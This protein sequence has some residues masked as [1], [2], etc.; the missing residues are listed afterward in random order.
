MKKTFILLPFIALAFTIACTPTAQT[1][2]PKTTTTQVA[3]P[4]TRSTSTVSA[5]DAANTAVYAAIDATATAQIAT[6]IAIP[7]A[8]SRPTTPTV[9]PTPGISFKYDP[10]VTSEQAKEI[11]DAVG[12]A[13][14]YLGTVYNVQ[15]YAF[16][17]LTC[18]PQQPDSS[19][20]TCPSVRGYLGIATSNLIE[21]NLATPSW[22]KSSSAGRKQVVVH[23]Y[24]HIVQNYSASKQSASPLSSGLGP[25]WLIEGGADYLSAWVVSTEHLTE[26]STIR[27]NAIT[28]AKRINAP[29]QTIESYSG[30]RAAGPGSEYTL[31]FF[32]TE[33]LAKNYGGEQN[34]LKFFRSIATSRTWHDAFKETFG[35]SREEFYGKFE[36]YRLANLPPNP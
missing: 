1:A 29:L 15:V 26:Y 7:V 34:I 9:S 12:L 4:A 31:G 21:L 23:E 35:I 14:K 32:G 6:I 16:S 28:R 27:D 24:V 17:D 11:E 22:Q 20:I 25:L 19:D 30:A 33:L 5:A 8:T 18:V 3:R 10:G 13:R 36:E 2:A